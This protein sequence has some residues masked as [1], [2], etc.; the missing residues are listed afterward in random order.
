MDDI[1]ER[2]LEAIKNHYEL[3]PVDQERF[4][5]IAERFD[6][7]IKAFYKAIKALVD[8]GDP[9]GVEIMLRLVSGMLLT[10]PEQMTQQVHMP[11]G[12]A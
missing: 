1:K 11:E 8:E 9:L 4:K 10:L 12:H 5:E 6:A 3:Q 7:E 2:I